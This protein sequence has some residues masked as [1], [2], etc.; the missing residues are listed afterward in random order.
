MTKTG[1]LLPKFS[2]KEV[3]KKIQIILSYWNTY[4]NT[5]VFIKYLGHYINL[6]S[7][8]TIW[9]EIH[10][11][12]KSTE[13]YLRKKGMETFKNNYQIPQKYTLTTSIN[14]DFS[15]R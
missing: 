3:S 9:N 6:I 14:V 11:K 2:S 8:K 12:K 7:T 10:I 13:W 1:N 5:P 15:L 4:V